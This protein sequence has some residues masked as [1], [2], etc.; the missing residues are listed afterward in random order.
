[1]KRRSREEILFKTVKEDNILP[2]T[3]ICKL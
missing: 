1:M 3:S 2:I